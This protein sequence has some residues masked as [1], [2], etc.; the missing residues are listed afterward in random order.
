MTRTDFDLAVPVIHFVWMAPIAILV[1][2]FYLYFA[3]DSTATAG[4][5][6][7]VLSLLFES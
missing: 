1:E 7:L 4:V 6:V 3:V 2:I 5:A